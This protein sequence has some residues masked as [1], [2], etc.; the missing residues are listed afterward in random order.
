MAAVLLDSRHRSGMGADVGRDVQRRQ[1]AQVQASRFAPAQELPCRRAYAAHVRSLASCA[2]KNS[3]NRS[4]AAGPASTIS[5]GS[6]IGAPPTIAVDVDV[7][8]SASL[9]LGS[10]HETDYKAR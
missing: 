8:T 3:R 4:A 9:M 7:G 6:A 2:A 10:P 1:G 5:C